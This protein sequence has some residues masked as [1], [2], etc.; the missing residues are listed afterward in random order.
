MLWW[1]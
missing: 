1:R